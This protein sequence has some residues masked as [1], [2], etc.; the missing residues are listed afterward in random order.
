LLGSDP[1]SNSDSNSNSNSNAASAKLNAEQSQAIQSITAALG[2]FKAFLLEGVTGSGKTEVYL[3]CIETVL[4]ANKQVLILVPEIGLTPQ[5]LQRLEERFS[6]P[7]ALLHSSLTEKQRLI[8]WEK[9]A[10]GIAP[11][12]LGTRSAAFTPLK[13]PGLFIIDEEHDPSFKQQDSFR[14]SARDLLIKRAALD[15]CPIVLGSATPSLETLANAERKRYQKLIL[16]T[17]ANNTELPPVEIIDIRHK[18]LTEGLSGTLLKKIKEHLAEKGQVL[19]FLNRRGFAPVLM[20]FDCGALAQC[21]HCDAKL[22]VHFKHQYLKCHHCD[23]TIPIYQKCP[24][25][26]GKNLNPLGVG[27]ERL[28]AALKLHFPDHESLRI[29]RDTTRRK[30]TFE[31]AISR[32]HDGD[33]HILLGTQMLAKGHHFP[34]LTLVAILDI[35]NAL[36][37]SDFRSIERLGQLLTQVAG[38]AG[39]AERAGQVVLQT[40]HPNHPL[41]HLLLKQGYS[42]FADNLLNERKMTSLPPFSYQALIR[43][44]ATKNELTL[45]FLEKL[46]KEA[47]TLAAE[48][49]KI[50]G[51]ISAPMERRAGKYHSQLLLQAHHRGEL[52]SLLE[53]LVKKIEIKGVAGSVRWSLDV[54]PIEMF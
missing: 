15:H 30:G 26:E 33:A 10:S 36:F 1:N 40:C 7:I 27:T 29:D 17:R 9:A 49:L 41:L 22:T 45:A 20:C 6:V 34:N 25:C 11:I 54:D 18:K 16:S 5:M 13:E 14:Y 46:K 35:D 38:R 8:A 32:I 39:R 31:E 48:Q 50:L 37:S 21:K 44:D 52:Q 23:F 19:L 2:T 43:A 42:A 3:Q 28:E 53:K 12:V 24:D 4:K 51:P 47:L